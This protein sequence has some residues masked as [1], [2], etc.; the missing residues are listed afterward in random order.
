MEK[1]AVRELVKVYKHGFRRQRR[2][3]LALDRV[4]FTV[5]EGIFTLLGPTGCG[6]TTVL[7]C[8]A[9]LE[10]PDAG[11]IIV[12]GKVV[13]GEGVNIHPEDRGVGM[14]FQSYAIWPHMTVFENVAF[15]L[16]ARGYSKDEIARLVKNALELVDLRVF[17]E[18]SSTTLRGGQQQR[19]ALARA[20]VHSPSVLL[21]DEPLSNLDAKLRY[22]MRMELKRL[23]KELKITT[24]FV[25][26]DQVEALA[27]SD[28]IAVM[29]AGKI[30]E[31]GS[32]YEIY[33]KP[34]KP[35]TAEFVG[36]VNVLR[37]K[38]SA[39]TGV[40]ETE[41]GP[42]EYSIQEGFDDYGEVVVY[43]RPEDVELY[44]TIKGLSNEFQ[45]VAETTAFMGH[46]TEVYVRVGNQRIRSWTMVS[47]NVRPGEKIYL[48][49][50]PEK[51]LVFPLKND[52]TIKYS[53]VF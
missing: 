6:K 36:S 25:T 12:D 17:E 13:F 44:G 8:I 26:H 15:P 27:I 3:V 38:I 20:L 48:R 32:P 50:D 30:V 4:T 53:S 19:V 9:G 35:F 40:V 51:V 29:N 18:R 23:L 10:T 37:G 52:Q 41:L 24:I 31:V 34:R 33:T 1:V 2:E 28:C 7:R 39:G 47:R 21:L 5:K 49:I 22:G 43:I 16:Q 46:F 45:G 14:V 42:I 11:E